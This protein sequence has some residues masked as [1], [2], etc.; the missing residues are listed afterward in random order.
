MTVNSHIYLE[1][2]SFFVEPSDIHKN[3]EQL[4]GFLSCLFFLGHVDLEFQIA[5]LK[6]YEKVYFI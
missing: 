3:Y 2:Q 4:K 6:R 1:V 5:T